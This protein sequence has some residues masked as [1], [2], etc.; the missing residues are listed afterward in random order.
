MNTYVALLRGINVGGHN[1]LSMDELI[2]VLENF[3]LKNVRT[4]IQSGNAVFQSKKTVGHA[5]SEDIS[6]AIESLK[7]FRPEVILLSSAEF[8]AAINTNPFDNADGKLLHLFFMHNAQLDADLKS[9]AAI[10]SP[11]EKFK[12][13][14]GIF[15][16]S[17]PDGIERSK[18]ARKIDKVMS[19]SVTARNW[20]TVRKI[21]E[22]IDAI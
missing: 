13:I 17:T 3:G 12:F 10:K 9:L 8:E 6:S 2:A 15:Y 14:N 20:N 4:Y 22:I 21:Q 5:F 19:G 18:L 11:S 16:L 7:G 1:S